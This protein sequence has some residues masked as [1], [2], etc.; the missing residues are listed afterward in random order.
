MHPCS[1]VWQHTIWTDLI[2][3]LAMF[4]SSEVFF[5]SNMRQDRPCF[6]KL[7]YSTKDILQNRAQKLCVHHTTTA[8]MQKILYRSC[9]QECVYYLN[10][11]CPQYELWL[12]VREVSL[13]LRRHANQ[14]TV[15]HNS[16]HTHGL[17]GELDTETERQQQSVQLGT[18]QRT[19]LLLFRSGQH[20]Y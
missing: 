5:C 2:D 14:C 1:H 10:S 12:W 11:N 15:C 18:V 4:L 7:Q 3:W 16:Y 8:A 9:T 20:V 6:I 13:D 19:W 17:K